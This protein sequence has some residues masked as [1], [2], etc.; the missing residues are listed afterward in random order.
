M[1]AHAS[2][3]YLRWLPG[4]QLLRNYDLSMLQHDVVAGLV[5]LPPILLNTLFKAGSAV[6]ITG[7]RKGWP[8]VSV[9]LASAAAPLLA[10]PFFL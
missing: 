3:R 4:V 8:G 2:S 9:L 7:W 10:L 6:A 5:L 1:K